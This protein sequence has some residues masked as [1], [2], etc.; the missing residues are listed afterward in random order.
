MVIGLCLKAIDPATFG[1]GMKSVVDWTLECIIAIGNFLSAIAIGNLEHGAL[2][3]PAR[4]HSIVLRKFQDLTLVSRSKAEKDTADSRGIENSAFFSPSSF[5]SST[6]LHLPCTPTTGT[7][8]PAQTNIPD[9]DAKSSSSHSSSFP[10]AAIIVVGIVGA[11]LALILSYKIYRCLWRRR[12]APL[13]ALDR[14]LLD[15]EE[16][17]YGYPDRQRP[18]STLD[19]KDSGFFGT[20]QSSRMSSLAYERSA[21]EASGSEPSTPPSA[22]TSFGGRNTPTHPP[23]TAT[24]PS[25]H[26]RYSSSPGPQNRHSMYAL[27]GAGGSFPRPSA[28]NRR[29]IY[30]MS[31]H[32]PLSSSRPAS[33]HSR[34]SSFHAAQLQPQQVRAPNRLS[35]AP[36]SVYSQ[37]EIIPP[38][39]LGKEY[40]TVMG[41]EKDKLGFSEASGIGLQRDDSDWFR[42]QVKSESQRTGLTEEEIGHA[43]MKRMRED[44]HSRQSSY[45]QE[46]P[47]VNSSLHL[48]ADGNSFPF[49]GPDPLGSTS[50]VASSP[51]ISRGGTLRTGDSGSSQ[52]DDEFFLAGASAASQP[53]DTTRGRLSG[54]TNSSMKR[55]PLDR[56]QKQAERESRR[57]GSDDSTVEGTVSSEPVGAVREGEGREGK[58]TEALDMGGKR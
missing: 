38:K 39:P 3:N 17:D 13:P 11:V 26:Q 27:G 16:A 33:F 58:V 2:E 10:L 30:A 47:S 28:S 45:S 15:K 9:A 35:G 52:D 31:L 18:V 8:L 50:R 37:I 49:Q 24:L 4:K 19:E 23:A 53:D 40:T 21:R 14:N 1:F 12:S 6:F 5:S 54:N 41:I 51:G 55:S 56:L 57:M 46:Q 36:H 20:G 34:P 29:S 44:P 22:Q 43:M 48:P 7:T 42:E 32:T 25:A